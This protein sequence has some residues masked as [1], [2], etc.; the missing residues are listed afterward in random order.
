MYK[1][2]ITI[3]HDYN[4]D[5]LL[6]LP[7]TLISIH[8]QMPLNQYKVSFSMDWSA[9][10]LLNFS[11]LSGA[12]HYHLSTPLY[13]GILMVRN[14]ECLIYFIHPLAYLQIHTQL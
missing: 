3:T 1:D 2:V 13:R 6:V 10:G 4:I 5:I 11:F 7:A 9:G 8:W 14:A 12:I